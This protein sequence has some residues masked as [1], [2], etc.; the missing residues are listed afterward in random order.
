M[1]KKIIVTASIFG[2]LAV[3]LGAMG[4]HALKPLLLPEQLITYETAA[5]YQMYHALALLML[6]ALSDK[7]N[8][9]FISYAWRF[10]VA[11]IILFSGSLYLIATHS[12]LG[13][14]N[15]LWLGP[16]TPLGGLC[17]ILGWICVMLSAIKST[18]IK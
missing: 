6:S 5:R 14:E 10:F 9:K 18:E 12:L 16:I 8:A 7:L 1:N 3:V 13:F 2:G 4:A 15:Y 17:F 11:G